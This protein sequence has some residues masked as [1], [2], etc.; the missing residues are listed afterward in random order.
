MRPEILHEEQAPG[1]GGQGATRSEGSFY[2][3]EGK[4]SL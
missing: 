1:A 3:G 2:K 4:S